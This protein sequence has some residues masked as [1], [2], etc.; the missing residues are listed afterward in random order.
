LIALADAL[1]D[2]GFD[3]IQAT[4]GDQRRRCME[5]AENFVSAVKAGIREARE[6]RGDFGTV[7]E[8]NHKG[9]KKKK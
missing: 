5:Y 9:K 7:P 4:N 8:T 6:N 1:K 3:E 2:L